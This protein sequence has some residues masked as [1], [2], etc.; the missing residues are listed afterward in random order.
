MS[1]ILAEP[2]SDELN[3]TDNV[4]Q[5]SVGDL[6][7]RPSVEN[8]Q[9]SPELF[10]PN[11]STVQIVIVAALFVVVGFITGAIIFS[12]RSLTARDVEAIVRSI[13]EDQRAVSSG[14][15]GQVDSVALIDDDPSFGPADAPV[16]IVEFSDYNCPFCTR[17][18]VETLPQLRQQYG[19]LIRFVYRD[20]PIIGGQSSIDAAVAGNCAHI[21]GKFWEFHDLLFANSEAREHDTYVAF[22]DELGMDTGAFTTCLDD[23]IQLDEVTLDYLD[24]QGLGIDGTPAFFING[25]TIRG[26]QPFDTFALVIDKELEKLGVAVPEPVDPVDGVPTE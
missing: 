13:I 20:L 23:K 3:V 9:T 19:S 2:N 17:F 18:A 8:S 15:G 14:S 5:Q 10:R 4:E 1:K 24:G 11:A 16:T 22:A 12:N 25:K 21:Q 6:P 7:L 26:A